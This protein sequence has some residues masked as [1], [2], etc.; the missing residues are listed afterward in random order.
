MLLSL[1]QLLRLKDKHSKVSVNC[2]EPKQNTIL[3][4][5][6]VM[7]VVMVIL[8]VVVMMMVVMM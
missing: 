1:V 3:K 4:L 7:M 8:M 6:I 5:M 2:L